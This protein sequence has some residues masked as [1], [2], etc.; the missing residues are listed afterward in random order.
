MDI[1][2]GRVAV[3]SA[4]LG[5]LPDDVVTNPEDARIDPRG[6]FPHPRHPLELEIGCGKGTFLLQQASAMPDTNFLGI[7][8][9]REFFEYTADRVRRAGLANVRVLNSDA[10]EFLRWRCAS[11]VFRVIHVYFPD[12]WPKRRHHRRRLIRDDF[13]QQCARVLLPGGEIRIVTDH[14][15]YWAWIQERVAGLTQCA[16]T[17]APPSLPPFACESFARAKG[18]GEGELVGTNFERKY[19]REGRPFHA[20]VLR[21]RVQA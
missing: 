19:R 16:N 4:E 15:D 1:A 10:A 2:P 20:I 5:S 18:A 17:H 8:I 12:P 7:E 14:D 11:D 9:A 6:W 3:S 13:L 21:R